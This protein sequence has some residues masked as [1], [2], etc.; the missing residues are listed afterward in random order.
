MSSLTILLVV[1][2]E[3]IIHIFDLLHSNVSDYFYHFLKKILLEYLLWY[4][5][6][7]LL[8]CCCHP[9]KSPSNCP[10]YL[11]HSETLLR[12]LSDLFHFYQSSNQAIQV[13]VSSKQ[14]T[15]K[16]QMSGHWET[17]RTTIN[18]VW[19]PRK[20]GKR[21]RKASNVKLPLNSM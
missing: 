9:L 7:L 2:I 20:C 21:K 6:F 12:Y 5:P 18:P 17:G 4:N 3:I 11:W 15:V 10:E 16:T 14:R 13:C 1:T 8:H 19:L